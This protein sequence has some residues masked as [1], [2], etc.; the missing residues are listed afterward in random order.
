MVVILKVGMRE[1]YVD[2]KVINEGEKIIIKKKTLY[3]SF[4]NN[5]FFIY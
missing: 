3:S 4:F 1:G 2:D 5:N